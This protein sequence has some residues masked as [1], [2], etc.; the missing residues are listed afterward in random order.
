MPG[1][2][3]KIVNLNKF[4]KSFIIRVLHRPTSTVYN[5]VEVGPNLS[6]KLTPTGWDISQPS[7]RSKE[8]RDVGRYK[9]DE[10]GFQK[11]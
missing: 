7:G 10:G 5:D 8:V 6:E 2:H 11:L 1:N 3:F 4:I 9:V